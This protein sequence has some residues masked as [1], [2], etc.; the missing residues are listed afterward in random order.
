MVL[1]PLY[2]DY[3]GGVVSVLSAV[4]V[5]FCVLSKGRISFSMLGGRTLQTFPKK[6]SFSNLNNNSFKNYCHLHNDIVIRVLRGTK[7]GEEQRR[8]K[9]AEN[10]TNFV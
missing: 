7:C 10:F 6:N 2:V 9:R 4:N 8:A 3:T 1:V 5:L